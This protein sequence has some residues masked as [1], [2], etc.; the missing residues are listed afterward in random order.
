MG[1]DTFIFNLGWYAVLMEYPPEVRFEVY[2]A[3]M[4]YATSGTLTELKPLAKMAFSFI[5]KEMDYNR[6]RY[7]TTVEKRR[8]AGKRSAEAKAKAKKEQSE[9]MSTNSTFDGDVQQNQQTQ[10][11]STNSTD[12]DNDNDNNKYDIIEEN[13][14]GNFLKNSKIDESVKSDLEQ[15]F[16]AFRMRYPGKRRGFKAE[17]DN[18]KRKN[19]KTWREIIPLLDP[20]LNR[21][22]EWNKQARAAGKFVPDFKNLS[23]WLNQQCW[24]DE[25]PDIESPTTQSSPA[26]VRKTTTAAD[27]DDDDDDAFQSKNR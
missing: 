26:T 10:Q 19:P 21:L 22:L 27:Y 1:K 5:K 11:M 7:E 14:N 12:N 6:E 3:I 9:Q 4:R 13:I 15:Q 8:E 24:T 18:F 20:A 17:F 2:E 25:F 23:T 16:D